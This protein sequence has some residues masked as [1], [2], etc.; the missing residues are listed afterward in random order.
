MAEEP[1]LQRLLQE[2]VAEHV[3]P[4]ARVL[5]AESLPIEPGMSGATVRR[6]CLAL[7][8]PTGEIATVRLVTKQAELRERRVLAWLVA[9]RQNAVPYSCAQDLTTDEPA[10]VCMQDV[11]DTSRPVSLDPITPEELQ[12]EVEGLAA[13]HAANLTP[14]ESLAGLPLI[15]RDY[16]AEY[17][18]NH[19]W[20]PHWEKAVANNDFHQEFRPFIGPVEAAVEPMIEAMTALAAE[21][22]GLTLVHTDIH[23]SNVLIH[24]GQPYYIDWQVAHRGPLYL[25]LPHHFCTLEQA[26][27][28]RRAMSALG[29]RIPAPAFEE[30]YQAA[31]RC[32][33][34]RYLWWT[35]ES[36][37]PEPRPTAWV[38]HYL[39]LI[40]G[41]D[42]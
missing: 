10:L 42:A 30:Q 31:A 16:F 17:V 37:R 27:L 35:L 25:D 32:V 3:S 13:I 34:F 6:Y 21:P 18:I 36:W 26:E 23:P 38:R 40:S 41:S 12:R 22:G 1:Q 19:S 7:E 5:G 29:T 2:T 24:E 14:C 4:H 28:Y 15:N 11:G 9:Q 33:G 8:Y 20:R 39:N